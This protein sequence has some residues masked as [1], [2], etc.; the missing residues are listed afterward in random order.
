MNVDVNVGDPIWPA[1]AD[2]VL[3]RLLETAPILLR[4]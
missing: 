1:P 4:G 3:P 2:V